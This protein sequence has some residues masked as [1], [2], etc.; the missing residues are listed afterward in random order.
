VSYLAFA[1]IAE[2]RR[3]SDHRPLMS[4]FFFFEKR[5]FVVFLDTIVSHLSSGIFLKWAVVITA[6][7]RAVADLY[8][9]SDSCGEPYF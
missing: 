4:S 6:L 7:G 3:F 8:S 9:G 1:V 2:S 5:A